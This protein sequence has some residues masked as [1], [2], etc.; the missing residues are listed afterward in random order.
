MRT[1]LYFRVLFFVGMGII[2]FPLVTAAAPYRMIGGRGQGMGGA[3]VASID[4]EHAG[5]WN[6]AL[7]GQQ[8]SFAGGIQANFQAQV[9]NDFLDE[10]QDLQDFEENYSSLDNIFEKS[11]SDTQAYANFIRLTK[12]LRDVNQP[13]QGLLVDAGGGLNFGRDGWSVTANNYS[14]FAGR[15]DFLLDNIVFSGMVGG[16]SKAIAREFISGDSS[17]TFPNKEPQKYSRET[18]DAIERELV[19]SLDGDDFA[20]V[21]GF[22]SDITTDSAANY[23]AWRLEEE[24]Y[25]ESTVT[26]EVLQDAAKTLMPSIVAVARG[27]TDGF[28]TEAQKVNVRGAMV[29]EVA[30]NYAHPRPVFKLLNSPLYLGGSVKLM[31]GEVGFMDLNVFDEEV[32]DQV[33]DALDHTEKS[34]DFGLDAGFI[35]DARQNLGL[36]AGLV[37]KYLN[38]PSFSYP[39]VKGAP[40]SLTIDP[41]WR[42]GLTGY[43][44]EW[45]YKI[46]TFAGGENYLGHDWW[47][48]SVDYDLTTNSTL[49]SDYDA[50]YLALGN[51]FNIFNRPWIN[52]ALRAGMRTNRAESREGTLYTAGLGMNLVRMNVDLSGTFSDKTTDDEDGSSTPTFLGAALN[53]SLRF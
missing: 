37:G 3:G 34:T 44:L 31:Q 46:P 17:T 52:L 20:N 35:W 13:G 49:L 28:D 6:P 48:I 29:N 30:F 51:E 26:D 9:T 32:E 16:D 12:E 43:P 42:A 18:V 14:S 7:V 10:A 15:T 8:K 1:N 19:D 53:F 50:R 45:I 25:D 11:Y 27:D 2:L 47:R 38:S 24:G 36:K 21:F 40:S 22:D 41:Q 4:D 5:L 23:I 39:D 33:S